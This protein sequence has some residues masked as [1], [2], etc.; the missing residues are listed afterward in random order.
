MSMST[1]W[2]KILGDLREGPTRALLVAIAIALGILA[3][4][5]TFG[6]SAILSREIA[7]S[8]QGTHPAAATDRAP[9]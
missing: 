6:A 8:F 9:I 5:A 1:R 7:S 4:S 2:R 3:V